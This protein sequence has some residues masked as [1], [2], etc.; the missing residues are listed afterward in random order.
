MTERKTKSQRGWQQWKPA[1]AR[2]ELKAWRES[3][4]PLATFARQRGVGDQRLRWWRERLGGEPAAGRTPATPEAIRLVP[5]IIKP[6]LLRGAGAALT[7]ELPGGIV[8]EISDPTLVPAEWLG[9][10]LRAV[11]AR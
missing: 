10:L 2:R 1:Q 7:A 8:L 6:A 11:T 3:G 4:L 9:T 5:A